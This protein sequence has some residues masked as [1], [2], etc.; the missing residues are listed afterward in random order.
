MRQSSKD[1]CLFF[2]LSRRAECYTINLYSPKQHSEKEYFMP[3]PKK[4]LVTAEDLYTL[5]QLSDVCISPDGG[6]VIYR[7]QRVDRKTEK[8]YGN[9][10]IVPTGGGEPRQFTYGNQSDSSPRWSPDGSTIAFLSSRAGNGNP[11]IHLIPFDGGEAR[12][13]TSI[14]GEI[15]IVGWS[16]DGR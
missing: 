13:L 3:A 1:G 10:W 12:K 16:P 11:Q 7:I 15:D 8:K 14:D 6:H 4:R 9:L 2:N 5:Q